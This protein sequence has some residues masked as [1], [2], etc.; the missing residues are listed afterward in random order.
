PD[1]HVE[2]FEAHPRGFAAVG[3]PVRAQWWDVREELRL[4]DFTTAGD[5]WVGEILPHNRQEATNHMILLAHES[6]RPP[7]MDHCV[8]AP[9]KP[10]NVRHV[11]EL[12]GYDRVA[13]Q[14]KA[15]WYSPLQG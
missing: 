3:P 10:I 2:E 15:F 4:S 14:G 1:A 5:D 9:C 13:R 12:H 11:V 7:N 8:S 6:H